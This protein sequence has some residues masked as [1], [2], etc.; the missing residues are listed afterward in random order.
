MSLVMNVCAY[1]Y[2]LDF[3]KLLFQGDPRSVA[4]SPVVQ[5]AYL[6]YASADA[7]AEAKRT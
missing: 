1:I 4:A 3:G 6:G 7:A 2:V 5:A